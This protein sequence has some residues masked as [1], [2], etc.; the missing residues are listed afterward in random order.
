MPRN[1]RE[2]ALRELDA[3]C[4]NTEWA[5]KHLLKVIDRYLE[6]HPEIA[7]PLNQALDVSAMFKG[8]V[9]RVRSSI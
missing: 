2:W 5:E 6:L 4:N 1:T 8:L 9:Q 7:L 3:A